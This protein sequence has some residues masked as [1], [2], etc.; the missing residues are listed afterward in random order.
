MQAISDLVIS[1]KNISGGKPLFKGTN[2]S[3]E[4][5]FQHIAN[6]FSLDEFIEAFPEISRG[7]AVDFLKIIIKQTAADKTGAYSEMIPKI[8]SLLANEKKTNE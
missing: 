6:G 2:V 1:D 3:T 5:L 4:T 7:Q 8:K